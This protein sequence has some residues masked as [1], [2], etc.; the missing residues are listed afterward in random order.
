MPVPPSTIK[1]LITNSDNQ[2]VGT[3]MMIK[4]KFGRTLAD[5]NPKKS[6]CNFAREH[7]TLIS[8]SSKHFF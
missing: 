6:K 4:V 5:K 1:I 7:L 3:Q 2:G 8:S